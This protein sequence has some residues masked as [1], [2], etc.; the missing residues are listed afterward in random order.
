[1]GRRADW[2]RVAQEIALEIPGT[3]DGSRTLTLTELFAR[4]GGQREPK[5]FRTRSYWAAEQRG[6][7][8]ASASRNAG[9][10][11]GFLPDETGRRVLSVP[12]RLDL[13]R[14]G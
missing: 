10:V 3:R 8:G 1:M 6:E 12:F 11:L 14:Q 5:A 4:S 9:L 13:L 2:R 7:P